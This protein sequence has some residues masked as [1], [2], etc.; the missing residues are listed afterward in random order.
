MEQVE[1]V[2]LAV[3]D[4]VVPVAVADQVAADVA[5]AVVAVVSG[6][7][8]AQSRSSRFDDAHVSSKVVADSAFRLWSLLATRTDGSAGVMGRRLKFPWL[9]KKLSRT[10][11][12]T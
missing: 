9:S 5:E 6:G 7:L 3:V 1:A 11:T 4:V 2:G 12:G 10:P 8:K